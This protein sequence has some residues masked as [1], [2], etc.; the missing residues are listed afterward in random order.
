MAYRRIGVSAYRRV[1]VSACR[2]AGVR[3]AVATKWPDRTAQGFSPGLGSQKDRP[4]G[5]TELDSARLHRRTGVNKKH[6]FSSAALSGRIHDGRHT[7][8]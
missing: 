2:R 6:G 8:G 1:G 4:E 7:Q 5:A 3:V